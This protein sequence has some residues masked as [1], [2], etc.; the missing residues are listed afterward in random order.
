MSRPS[1]CTIPRPMPTPSTMTSAG[2]SSP[3]LNADELPD[4]GQLDPHPDDT[5]EVEYVAAL[6]VARQ[7]ELGADRPVAAILGRAEIP[8]MDDQLIMRRGFVA[9]EAV[10]RADAGAA[11]LR[12]LLIL[13]LEDFLWQAACECLR[14][15][16][17]SSS[18]GSADRRPCASR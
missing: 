18:A 1:S 7:A 12:V 17:A 11:E 14:R 13:A 2:L 6:L 9:R 4:V 8:G 15:R 16:P 5:Q 3:V 10:D